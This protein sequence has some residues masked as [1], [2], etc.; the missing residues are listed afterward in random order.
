MIKSN[1]RLDEEMNLYKA[2]NDEFSLSI[3]YKRTKKIKNKEQFR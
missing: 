3:Y 2:I 1:I